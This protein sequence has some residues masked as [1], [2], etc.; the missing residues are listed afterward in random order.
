MSAGWT[1]RVVLSGVAAAALAATPFAVAVNSHA[2]APKHPEYHKT[3]EDGAL[4]KPLKKG[5]KAKS[6]KGKATEGGNNSYVH[7]L[8]GKGGKAGSKWSDI[9]LKRGR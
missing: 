5:L 9:E 4:R 8:P 7:R 2:Q 3:W 1:S 6:P